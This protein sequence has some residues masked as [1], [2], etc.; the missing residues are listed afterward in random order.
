MNL[1]NKVSISR[2]LLVPVFML[3]VLSDI[4]YGNYAAT[5]WTG[6]LQEAEN[7]LQNSAFF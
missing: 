1:A 6:I 4:K 3:F 5:E 2:I 7:R